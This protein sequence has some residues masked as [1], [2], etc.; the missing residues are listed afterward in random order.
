MLVKN[1][2]RSKLN[3]DALPSHLTT[4][5]QRY[6]FRVALVAFR[7]RKITAPTLPLLV[8]HSACDDDDILIRSSHEALW[9]RTGGPDQGALVA[10]RASA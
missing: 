7:L 10:Y 1:H 8:V 4:A 5:V 2:R 9:V 6:I 3:T